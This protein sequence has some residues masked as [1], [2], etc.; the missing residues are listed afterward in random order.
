MV[1]LGAPLLVLLG[2][3]SCEWGQGNRMRQPRNWEMK[4]EEAAASL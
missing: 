1:V 2:N 3:S 4:V